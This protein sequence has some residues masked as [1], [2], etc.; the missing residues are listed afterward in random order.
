MNILT[1][2]WDWLIKQVASPNIC[3]P[4]LPLIEVPEIL[5]IQVFRYS[6]KKQECDTY[7]AYFQHG[8]TTEI[9]RSSLNYLYLGLNFLGY[10]VQQ[11][12]TLKDSFSPQ[13]F[14]PECLNYVIE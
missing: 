10:K 14:V 3:Y 9:T 12:L 11:D 8:K 4:C 2:S 13:Q 7:L 1:K 6:T 5:N